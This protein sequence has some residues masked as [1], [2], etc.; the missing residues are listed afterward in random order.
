MTAAD[1]VV[2]VVEDNKTN[3]RLFNDVLTSHGYTVLQAMDGAGA[4]QLAKEH[5]PDAIILD[6]Q[7]P[8][9]SGLDVVKKLKQDENLKPIPVIATTA[10]AMHGD[11]ETCL[12][13]GCDGYIPKPISVFDFLQTVDEFVDNR[14]SA[15]CAVE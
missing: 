11:K 6:I 10:F 12:Q 15:V 7:L 4:W 5:R 3:M 2:L 14:K 13:N 8:D 9:M 1:K